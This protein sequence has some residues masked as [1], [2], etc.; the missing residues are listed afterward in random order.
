MGKTEAFWRGLPEKTLSEKGKRCSGGKEAK[1]RNTWAFF[2]NAAGEKE[3]PVVIGKYARPRY[4]KNLKDA[5]HPY[6][7]Q[8]F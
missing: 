3:N 4:F 8:Y 1:Q 6:K 5:K 7:C 2:V